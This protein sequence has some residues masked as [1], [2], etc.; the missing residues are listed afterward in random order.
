MF[1]EHE[2]RMIENRSVTNVSDRSKKVQM[3]ETIYERDEELVRLYVF[4]SFGEHVNNCLAKYIGYTEQK[5][6]N[7]RKR[8]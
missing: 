4:F 7:K 3:L 2:Q 1:P 5:K 8:E 6:I